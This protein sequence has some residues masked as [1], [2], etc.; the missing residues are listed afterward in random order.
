MLVLVSTVTAVGRSNCSAVSATGECSLVTGELC[1]AFGC[2]RSCCQ[3]R[4]KI[5]TASCCYSVLLWLLQKWL[6]AEVLVAG[7]FELRWKELREMFGL[8]ICVLS[9][10]DEMDVDPWLG[11]NEY[12]LEIPE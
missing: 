11:L 10:M 2:H 1:R 12:M 6:G 5:A 4:F 9:Q 3:G 8:W 7:D